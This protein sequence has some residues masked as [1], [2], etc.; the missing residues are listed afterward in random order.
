MPNYGVLWVLCEWCVSG[1]W[2][3]R[4]WC[5]SGVWV[6]L[7]VVWS[8]NTRQDGDDI[9]NKQQKLNLFSVFF[10]LYY[11]VSHT[12]YSVS[13]R[14]ETSETNPFFSL[15]RFAHSRFRFALFRFEAKF[16]DTLVGKVSWSLVTFKEQHTVFPLIHHF[17]C[18]TGN[19]A[20]LQCIARE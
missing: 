7:S 15:F 12:K 10:T 19:K 20:V 13:L 3:V 2:V 14:S 9:S 18:A 16:G 6:L 4:E 17:Y 8:K 11:F 5:V 1:E